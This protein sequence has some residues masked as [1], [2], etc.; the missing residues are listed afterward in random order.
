MQTTARV[1]SRSKP[2]N[3]SRRPRQ[4][5]RADCRLRRRPRLTV[6]AGRALRQS[7]V[8]AE[9]GRRRTPRGHPAGKRGSRAPARRR[10]ERSR[11]ARSRARHAP[12]PMLA[13]PERL[14]RL[15]LLRRANSAA[16]ILRPARRDVARGGRAIVRPLVADARLPART[17]IEHPIDLGSGC[18]AAC[19]APWL[20]RWTSQRGDG[21]DARHALLI[22][23]SGG[24]RAGRRDVEH[25]TRQPVA[26]RG[27]ARDRSRRGV[28]ALH[29]RT[30]AAARR[31]TANVFARVSSV[32][33]STDR[34]SSAD[35]RRV[36]GRAARGGVS[37]R[38]ERDSS[39]ARD[40]PLLRAA[41]TGRQPIASCRRHRVG[42]APARR[43]QQMRQHM[44]CRGC[45]TS[46]SPSCTA[47][48][49]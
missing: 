3:R 16:G 22:A 21:P 25:L 41:R 23:S 1:Q 10:L 34:Q 36:V 32:R 48:S 38:A 18:R 28:G 19:R 29:E 47:C 4:R 5:E 13:G 14:A 42:S 39:R 20:Y 9:M 43:P 24:D 44:T 37:V 15:A 33:S 31:H 7:S 6:G 46:R 27:P 30:R 8:E 26:R 45:S 2:L 35:V 11:G 49:S 40:H 12:H 17:G